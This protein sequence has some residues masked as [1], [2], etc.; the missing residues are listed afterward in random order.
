[1]KAVEKHLLVDGYNMIHRIGSLSRIFAEEP[2]AACEALVRM[3]GAIHDEEG[4]RVT[5]VFDGREKRIQV[6]E[7]CG[8]PTFAVVYAPRHLTADGVIEQ[9]LARSKNP[10]GV[11]VASRD[12][13]IREA[14]AA[15]GAF[16]IDGDAF[17]AWV[18]R[19]EERTRSRLRPKAAGGWKRSIGDIWEG[20]GPREGGK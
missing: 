14:A 12:N 3:A 19:C 9:L 17:E 11:T 6:L 4:I 1:M 7:P 15:R 16:F 20:S 13:M 8:R 10:G 5:V 18:G 2:E